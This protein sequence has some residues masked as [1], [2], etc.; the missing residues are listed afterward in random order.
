MFL[1]LKLHPE[2][3]PFNRILALDEQGHQIKIELSRCGFGK[4]DVPAL[5]GYITK[6][7]AVRFQD[8]FPEASQVVRRH[9]IVDDGMTSVATE[10]E[11]IELIYDL[12]DLYG[13][14]G[15]SVRKWSS[16]SAR[17]LSI[18]P[19]ELR[20][21]SIDL[22]MVGASVELP[23]ARDTQPSLPTVK[24]LGVMWIATTDLFTFRPDS[25]LPIQW[26]K[27]LILPAYSKV[28]DPLGFALPFIIR[29]RM[30]FQDLWA[31]GL[32]W[33]DPI[34]DRSLYQWEAW[35]KEL[36]TLAQLSLPRCLQKE[37]RESSV[38]EQT[39]H[40]FTDA[41]G[42]A[43]GAC[44]YL[45]ALYE[46]DTVE[47]RLVNSRGKLCP[48]EKH[49]I[50]RKELVGAVSGVYLAKVASE[51]LDLPLSLATFWTDSRT[52]LIW[53]TVSTRFL[54]DFVG[55]RV[56]ILREETAARQWRY[57]P[58]D[59]NLA[60]L[61]TRGK[62]PLELQTS[63]LWRSGPAF[64][65]KPPHCW[66]ELPDCAA[67]ECVM[68]EVKKGHALHPSKAFSFFAAA[69][70]KSGSRPV[71][72]RDSRPLRDE[73][74]PEESEP[75]FPGKYSSFNF[76][77]RLVAW[78][79]R[80]RS[81][82]VPGGG[83]VVEVTEEQQ[84]EERLRRQQ[85]YQARRNKNTYISAEEFRAAKLVLL[86]RAQGQSFQ[87]LLTQLQRH[88][89][90]SP[91]GSLA[92]FDPYLA[93]DGL[94]KLNGRLAHATNLSPDQ[95]CPVLLH[96]DHPLTKLLF[97]STHSERLEHRAGRSTLAAI[98]A[99]DYFIPR[100]GSL[101]RSIVQTCTLCRRA[102]GQRNP[103]Q[104]AP[105][106]DFRS[107]P[108][109]DTPPALH[110]TGVDAAGPF[111]IKYGRGKARAKRYFLLFTCSLYRTV[112]LEFL[113]SLE[114]SSV[115]SAIQRFIARRGTPH[116]FVSD[117]AKSFV[118]A[119]LELQAFWTAF[120]WAALQVK[121][122]EI[123]W[124]FIPPR[125]PHEG[126]FWERLIGLTKQSLFKTLPA[127]ELS[128]EQFRTHLVMTEGVLNARPLCLHSTR[129]PDD[130]VP[131]TPNDFLR[132]SGHPTQNQDYAPVPLQVPARP[133]LV[134][135]FHTLQTQGDHFWQ[136]FVREFLPSLH[137]RNK[138]LTPVPEIQQGDVVLFLEEKLQGLWPLARVVA[139]YPTPRD[140]VI[141]HVDIKFRGKTIRRSVRT[142]VPL[143]YL[144]T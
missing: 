112:H 34:P 108:T 28:F 80:A 37:G 97:Y 116:S 26:T 52:V 38:V 143:P 68:K 31:L 14:A 39:L 7:H 3:W 56:G 41:S 137:G 87:G 51:A 25:V 102:V 122:P 24:A 67:S 93:D 27:R 72:D 12:I 101:A 77:V 19:A 86:R 32:G 43:Y 113:Y 1:Q 94:V 84:A 33:D 130:L 100:G 75:F 121:L 46:D 50:P 78:A 60:D 99:Q 69:D 65:A 13:R 58:T 49:T 92:R 103:V 11:A 134:K 89:R 29:A 61:L 35:L 20:A 81:W 64:L 139:V 48:P 73:C 15:M 119:D 128:E 141:R 54:S 85:G 18:V 10:E 138:W 71:L 17:A 57:V 91:N 8:R 55:T 88:E 131:L 135:A 21:P 114:T 4:T 82:L 136:R 76:L 62:T 45:R 2:E 144:R 9:T 142:V 83:Q 125:A 107:A 105:L 123:R 106:P 127:G 66:P 53:G 16:S 44:L 23:P 90:P 126:G 63:D 95:R 42:R 22:N 96:K 109:K 124:A 132:W 79:R 5:A 118:R 104:M 140:G 47:V 120:P 115:L 59:D 70:T 129:D 30:I 110:Y 40:C 36:P 133:T 74:L 111:L 117:N 98:M 6:K